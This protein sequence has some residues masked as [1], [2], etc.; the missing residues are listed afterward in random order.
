MKVLIVEDDPDVREMLVEI[1][2]AYEWDVLAVAET[3]LALATLR[4][5]SVDL[6]ISDENLEGAS[7]SAMLEEA[8]SAGLLFNVGAMIYTAE[9][10]ELHVPEG[11]RVLQKPLGVSSL[12]DEANAVIARSA[13]SSR[14]FRSRAREFREE[15]SESP[16][17]SA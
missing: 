16:P 15:E 9:P 7:G 11:V 13:R 3:A 6:V 4:R 8:S 2:R 17:S 14:P 1:F 12:L 5:D 10:R